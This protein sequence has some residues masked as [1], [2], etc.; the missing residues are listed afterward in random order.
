M[1][2]YYK[3]CTE[4]YRVKEIKTTPKNKNKISRQACCCSFPPGHYFQI[5]N[6]PRLDQIS[7]FFIAEEF[8]G[9]EIS[10]FLKKRAIMQ[11]KLKIKS[12][13]FM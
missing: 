2:I 4:H 13:D 11:M 6:V 9:L 5:F 7:A 1:S 10:L 3:F 8:I 12:S